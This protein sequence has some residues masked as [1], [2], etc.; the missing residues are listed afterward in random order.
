MQ[1]K[2]ITLDLLMDSESE[3][4]AVGRPGGPSES[5]GLPVTVHRPRLT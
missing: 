2:I 3:F 1:L 4:G 5:A